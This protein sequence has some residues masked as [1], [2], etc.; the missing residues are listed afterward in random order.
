MSTYQQK[1]SRA[2][3]DE[4]LCADTDK[5]PICVFPCCV[6]ILTQSVKVKLQQH[7]FQKCFGTIFGCD[8]LK[9]ER[10]TNG[11]FVCCVC[12]TNK[13][14]CVYTH[15]HTHLPMC[16]CACVCSAIIIRVYIHHAPS[17][18]VLAGSGVVTISEG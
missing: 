15:T 16:V 17:Q 4:A 5:V 9:L 12:A 1:Y 8:R 10:L 14:V 13:S 2:N 11:K 6:Q 3:T 7:L 18:S